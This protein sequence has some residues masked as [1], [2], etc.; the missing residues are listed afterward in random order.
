[1]QQNKGDETPKKKKVPVDK[2]KDSKFSS[3]DIQKLL[4]EVLL[5]S[6]Q[7]DLRKQDI[8]LEAISSTLE[9]FLRSFILI[10]YD[11]NNQPI[12]ITNAKTQLDADALYTAL[13]RVFMHMNAMGGDH[14]NI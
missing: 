10:G 2:K 13:A 12:V 7:D 5:E 14:D 8:E 3:T 9:E 11:T 1:M 6:I 4:N